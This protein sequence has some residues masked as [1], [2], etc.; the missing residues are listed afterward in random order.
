MYVFDP[1]I[2]QVEQRDYDIAGLVF[3]IRQYH[4]VNY[5]NIPIIL[6]YVDIGQAEDWR[7]YCNYTCKVG[8]PDWIVGEDPNGWTGNFPVKYWEQVWK[9]LVI[10]GDANGMS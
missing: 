6:A 3:D 1:L 8:D 5:N 2:T 10:Y 9:D 4:Q 7:W